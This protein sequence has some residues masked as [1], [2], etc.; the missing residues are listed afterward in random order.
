MLFVPVAEGRLL[1]TELGMFGL[2]WRDNNMIGS[3]TETVFGMLMGAL[4]LSVRV[5]T[6][7]NMMMM[8]VAVSC[9][10]NFFGEGRVQKLTLL[11]A[12][13]SLRL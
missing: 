3:K 6:K 1:V 10:V 9:V 11:L 7:G 13:F 4:V 2:W 12:H 5:G 8:M